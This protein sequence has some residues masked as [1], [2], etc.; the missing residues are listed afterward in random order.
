MENM[1]TQ[2]PKTPS[3][4]LRR[5]TRAEFN[6]L[7]KD[8]FF[9]DDERVELIFGMVVTMAPIDQAHIES[10]Y[11]VQ[12]MLLKRLEG[13]AR[14]YCEGALAASDES[15]PRPDVMVIRQG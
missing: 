2:D 3:L 12:T 9:R 8:G 15:E 4:P 5:I 7:G 10:T 6:K 11:H 14:V 1:D 13:R